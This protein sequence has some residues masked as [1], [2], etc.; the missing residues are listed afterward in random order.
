[1]PDAS[2]SGLQPIAAEMCLYSNHCYMRRNII[3]LVFFMALL[4]CVRHDLDGKSPELAV[5][6]AKKLCQKSSEEMVWLKD[7]IQQSETDASWRGNVYAINLDSRIVFVHQPFIMSCMGCLMYD[8]DGTK[9]DY[10]SIDH[11]RLV[12]LMTSANIIYA[13]PFE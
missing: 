9:I 13:P 3:R 11:Q 2:L 5:S 1:M 7:L 8:C 10:A 12:T 6:V 4:S